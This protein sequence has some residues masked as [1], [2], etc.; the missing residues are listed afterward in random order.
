MARVWVLRM[1]SQAGVITGADPMVYV[2]GAP[3]A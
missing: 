3:L 2:N 1:P